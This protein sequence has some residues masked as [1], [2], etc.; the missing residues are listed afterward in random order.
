MPESGQNDA[1]AKR[2]NTI[3][4]PLG[5]QLDT[6]KVNLV[7]KGQF[8]LYDNTPFEISGDTLARSIPVM[9]RFGNSYPQYYV[10]KTVLNS[11]SGE[12]S[13]ILF[14]DRAI[15]RGF[16]EYVVKIPRSR[17]TARSILIIEKPRFNV[18]RVPFRARWISEEELFSLVKKN[19][20]DT[21]H[22]H[23]ESREKQQKRTAMVY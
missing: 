19:G 12:N 5:L 1:P 9:D 20:I 16:A 4:K 21:R 14:K 3:S 11:D 7:T 2:G 22:Y 17:D 18:R 10:R 23:R 6:I 13:I 8:R 15:F